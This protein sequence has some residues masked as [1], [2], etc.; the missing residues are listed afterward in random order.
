MAPDRDHPHLRGRLPGLWRRKVWRQLQ[1]EGHQVA[2]CTVERLM[3]EL[4]LADVRRGRKVRTT[5]GD[6]GHERAVDL[7]RRDFTASSPNRR[8]VADFTHMTT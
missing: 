6:D 3:R 8:W 4:G 5:A 1:R 7:L 2:R